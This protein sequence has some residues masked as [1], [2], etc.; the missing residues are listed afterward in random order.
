MIN[1]V[2]IQD[3]ICNT[4]KHKKGKIF[5]LPI[6]KRTI[7]V[8]SCSTYPLAEKF[9]YEINTCSNYESGQ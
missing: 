4:C 7:P 1:K 2:S 5:I 9:C 8:F 6:S 3:I